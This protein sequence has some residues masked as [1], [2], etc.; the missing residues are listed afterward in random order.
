[1]HAQQWVPDLLDVPVCDFVRQRDVLREE[2]EAAQP[3]IERADAQR[4][5]IQRTIATVLKLWPDDVFM[6]S[7]LLACVLPAAVA[8][9]RQCVRIARVSPPRI[10]APLGVRV[11]VLAPRQGSCSQGR[12]ERRRLGSAGTHRR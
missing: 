10:N 2:L 3:F 4:L 11:Q 8:V 5:K 6:P 9:S 1:M 7:A 12:H